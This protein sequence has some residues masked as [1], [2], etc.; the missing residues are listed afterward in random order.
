MTDRYVSSAQYLLIDYAWVGNQ[1]LFPNAI[2]YP[3]PNP[4]DPGDEDAILFE[5]C[6]ECES[7]IQEWLNDRTNN[8]R[9]PTRPFGGLE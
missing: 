8:P 9:K 3:V 2:L 4:P 6:H 7:A 5:Y 1:H